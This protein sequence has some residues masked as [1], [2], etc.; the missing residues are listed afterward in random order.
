V[1]SCAADINRHP[2][3]STQPGRW[4]SSAGI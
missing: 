2:S 1:Y 4:L 3:F